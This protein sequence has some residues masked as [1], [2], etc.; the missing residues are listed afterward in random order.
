M[1]HHTFNSKKVEFSDR[2]TLRGLRIFIVLEETK[3]VA[4]AAERMGLSKS[5]VSQHIT[6]LETNVGIKLFDRKQKPIALTPA[7]QVL[8]MHAHRIASM[9]SVAETALA[10]FNAFSLPILNFAIIDDLDASLTPV[11]ATALQ[12]Q[13]SKS[14]IRT[15][16][17]RS[18]QV[19]SQMESR[20]ADIAVTASMPANVN[21][22]Q[23]HELYREQFVLVAAK[24]KYQPDLDW[25]K[26]L[27]EL[28][29]IQYSEAMP[30]G[31]LVATHLKRIRLDIPRQ[32]SFENSRS[33]IA[34]VAKAGG[35]T[36][37]TPLSILDASR[38]RD[39]I[40]LFALPFASLSRNVFLINRLNELGTLPEVLATIFRSELKDE[41]LPEF[42]KSNPEMVGMLEVFDGDMI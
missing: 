26:Q 3:S 42:A 10:D 19:T 14:F 12:A 20:E 41:L 27:T 7:G 35:W 1:N 30:M 6:T 5:S 24:D 17:G 32:F 38:F 40:S 4:L 9:F 8:S 29:F 37:A 33:V 21:E 16:S 34:T 13:L 18:D 11:M 39:E 31:Q 22:F 36:L 23:I 25:R 15:F 2:L 28:P